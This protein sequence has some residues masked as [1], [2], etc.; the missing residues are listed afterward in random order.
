MLSIVLLLDENRTLLWRISSSPGYYSLNTF[1]PLPL[2]VQHS[3]YPFI[4]ITIHFQT[5]ENDQTT[6]EIDFQLYLSNATISTK[7][8]LR[9]AL[10]KICGDAME[11]TGELY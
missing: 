7:T 10:R 3:P 1:L 6:D 11:V 4:I 8:F 5:I 2:L 9:F